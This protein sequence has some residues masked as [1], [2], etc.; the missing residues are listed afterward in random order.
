MLQ[1]KCRRGTEYVPGTE[2]QGFSS[3]LRNVIRAYC[4]RLGFSCFFIIQP[5]KHFL[6]KQIIDINVYAAYSTME[7]AR[8]RLKEVIFH[9]KCIHKQ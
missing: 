3:S 7:K 2:L 5:C 8:L 1:K 4:S 6:S 9:Y